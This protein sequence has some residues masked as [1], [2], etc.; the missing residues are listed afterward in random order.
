MS[1]AYV[2][3][4]NGERSKIWGAQHYKVSISL[5]IYISGGEGTILRHDPSPHPVPP[6]L[7]DIRENAKVKKA[8]VNKQKLYMYLHIALVLP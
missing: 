2:Y 7:M 6:A 4:R 3:G 5:S 8:K 1:T